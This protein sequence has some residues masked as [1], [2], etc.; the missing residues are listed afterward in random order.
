MSWSNVLDYIEPRDFHAM[1][2]ACGGKGAVHYGHSMNWVRDMKGASW[3]DV[4]ATLP[5]DA[6]S[7]FLKTT[8][9]K[10]RTKMLPELCMAMEWTQ[11]L[12]CPPVD[13]SMNLIDYA[14]CMLHHK[15]WANHFFKASSIVDLDRQVARVT[16]FS[17]AEW[18][19][20][21]STFYMKW[22]YDAEVKLK[23]HMSSDTRSGHP[24]S[25]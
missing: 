16:L 11:I 12:V 23:R 18:D 25:K 22:S 15:T 14:L 19:E 1:A 6:A 9:V 10:T 8:L 4:K 24:A 17:R 13:N 5:G 20:S 21:N 7:E 2:E 3:L